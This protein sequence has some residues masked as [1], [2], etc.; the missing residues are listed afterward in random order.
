MVISSVITILFLTY[1]F[2][3]RA[4]FL[5]IQV[6][7]G[8]QGLQQIQVL[9][10]SSLQT[11]QGQVLLQQPQQAQIVQSIDGQTF[12]YQPMAIDNSALQQTQPT[13]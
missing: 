13:G 8:A 5:K 4:Y 2:V 7:A 1:K 6:N 3:S 12:I 9:P 11:A 10:M